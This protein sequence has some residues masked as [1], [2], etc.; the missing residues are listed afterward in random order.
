METKFSELALVYYIDKEVKG[1]A[2]VRGLRQ[3]PDKW[4]YPVVPVFRCHLYDVIP[5]KGRGDYL[6]SDEAT[7]FFD[8]TVQENLTYWVC[9]INWAV[10]KVH[11]STMDTKYDIGVLV[12]YPSV[13]QGTWRCIN[14]E[15]VKQGYGLAVGP[16]YDV[17]QNHIS[18]P[19]RF[20]FK[21]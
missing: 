16:G 4:L 1:L 20:N 15:M 9:P 14:Y 17:L 21:L 8:K 19:Q 3:L 10:A 6:W 7:A 12:F 5:I 18:Y 2:P 11:G 13:K